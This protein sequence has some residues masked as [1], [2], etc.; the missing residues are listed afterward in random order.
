MLKGMLDTNVIFYLMIAAG[1]IGA[2]AKLV[3]R[4][5][6][7]R[8]V[9]ASAGM[10]K[11]T[12]KLMKLVRAKYE[13]ACMAHNTVDNTQAFVEKFIYEYRTLGLRLHTWQQLEKESLWFTA[14][15]ALLGAAAHYN[16]HGAGEMVYRYAMTGVAEVIL[17]ATFFQ[18]S[19]ERYKIGIVQVYMIDYLENVHAHRFQKFKQYD[20]E[21]LDIINPEVFAQPA[22]KPDRQQVKESLA[23]NIE[24]EPKG[25]KKGEGNVRKTG[26][27]LSARGETAR[28]AVHNMLKS[29]GKEEALTTEDEI[30]TDRIP[31]NHTEE[32]EEET[33][34]VDAIRH[35][36]EEFLA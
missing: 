24:E 20:K 16:A 3:S 30:E 32:N 15:L 29:S 21:K 17:L 25:T 31:E 9:K 33:L 12:H 7:N 1:I 34:R 27:V 23:I 4:T 28:Q 6:V 11:S 36:L 14:I 18:M 5:T 26:S 35:I 8:L 22:E 2:L 13:H 19:D 10:Q